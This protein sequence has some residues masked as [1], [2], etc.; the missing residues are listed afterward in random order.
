[1]SR[2]RPTRPRPDRPLR[3]AAAAAL[4]AAGLLLLPALLGAQSGEP[5]PPPVFVERIDVNVINVEVFVTDGQGRPV[6]GLTRDDFEIVHDG[7]PVEISN[8]FTVSRRDR[9][10]ME[11]ARAAAAEA[12]AA[13]VP[14][15]V[16]ASDLPEDQQLNLLVYL[17]HYNL[18]PQNRTRVLDTL[19][20][21]LEDRLFQGD[22]VMIVGYDGQLDV[23]Q[24]FTRDVA[25]IGSALSRI[26]T[27]KTH[28]QY[29]D[30]ERRRVLDNVRS[31]ALDLSEPDPQLA[32]GYVRAY[33]AEQQ[34]ELRRSAA[35]LSQ[36]VRSLAGLPGRKALLYVSDGLPRRPGEDVYLYMSEIFGSTVI[37]GTTDRPSD[38]VDTFNATLLADQNHLFDDITRHANAHQVTLYTLDARGSGGHSIAGAQERALV[39]DNRV[40]MDALQTTNF[41]EPLIEMA[42]ATGGRSIINT[43]AYQ[44]ALAAA[45]SDF[46]HFYSLGFSSPEAGDGDWHRI[47]VRV[48]RPGL[49]VRHRTGYVDKPVEERV[50]DRTLSSLI[51][52]MEMNPLGVEIEFGRPERQRRGVFHLPVLVRVPMSEVTLLPNGD[53]QE[54]RLRFF[55]AVKD[56]AGG[57]SD[58]H[59]Q[60]YPVRVPQE[61]V[62][63][64]RGK[65]IGYG[66][67]LRIG[68]GTPRVAVGVWDEI[69]GTESF[70][71]KEVLVE[72]ERG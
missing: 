14:A 9:V 50:A 53:V 52:E 29:Y 8:F 54:G 21:F 61:Q 40:A 49:H 51:F 72:R 30:A 47:E 11:L 26:D 6:T 67:T 22:R 33:I 2:T 35:A 57:V 45:A 56:D 44:D 7:R 39:A 41:Q 70:V 17:D 15:T 64:A 34:T 13:G 71:H 32:D 48:K 69:S 43:S 23:V 65:E 4:A 63:A 28:G 38:F 66:A 18:R 1:M 59:E 58:P 60:I 24:P 20:G 5:D 19:G 27:I 62:E 31:A 16:P 37:Q 36:M 68:P 55:L 10:A 3:F 46:D 25:D 12:P 42:E